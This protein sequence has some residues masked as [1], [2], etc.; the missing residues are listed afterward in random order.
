RADPRLGS[1]SRD[2]LRVRLL[3]IPYGGLLVVAGEEFWQRL[4]F[5]VLTADLRG[6]VA[7][8]VAQRLRQPAGVDEKPFSLLRHIALFEVVDEL[9][10]PLTGALP[11]RLEDPALRHAAQ[12]IVDRR[13]PAGFDHVQP[14]SLCEAIGL[15]KAAVEP[16]LRGAGAAVAVGLLVEGVHAVA[17]PAVPRGSRRRVR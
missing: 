9:R 10:G 11:D 7:V 15:A 4:G 2:D 5:T 17:A 12:V 8:V 14:D 3:R 6:L 1:F 16:L 13:P